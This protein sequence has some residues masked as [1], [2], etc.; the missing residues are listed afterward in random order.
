VRTVEAI[1]RAWKADL[2]V[3]TG[4]ILDGGRMG[5]A[6]L[7]LLVGTPVPLGALAIPGNHEYYTG[8]RACIE[9]YEG[10]GFRVLRDE[11]LDVKRDGQVVLRAVGMD[12]P[13][14]RQDGLPR[15]PPE[16]A[17][18]P[19]ADT[20]RPFTLLLKH[21]PVVD[22]AAIGRFDLQLSGHTHGGQIWPFGRVVRDVYGFDTGLH[23]L[24]KGSLLYL[25]P[26]AGTWGPPMRFLQ[27]AEITLFVL[28]AAK[29]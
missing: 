21:R 25:S 5:E 23:N 16:S 26:G 22:P 24:G 20:E 19:A 28:E 9:T 15:P 14:R 27:P 29:Q 11:S 1:L 7:G 2:L 3:T 18:L 4:D 8:I 10:A 12:D 13:A 6:P 17:L